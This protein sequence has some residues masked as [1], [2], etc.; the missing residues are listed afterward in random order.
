M[1]EKERKREESNGRIKK[2]NRRK[3]RGGKKVGEETKRG[4][5]KNEEREVR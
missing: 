1:K 5:G 3:K 4:R 2:G